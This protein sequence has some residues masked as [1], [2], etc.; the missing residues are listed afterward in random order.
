MSISSAVVDACDFTVDVWRVWLGMQPLLPQLLHFK[1]DKPP[2]VREAVEIEIETRRTRLVLLRA[3][4][5]GE[6]LH[7]GPVPGEGKVTIVPLTPE[8]IEFQITME[9]AHPAGRLQRHESVLE[10][11]PNGPAIESFDA[12]STVTLGG[13]IG[14]GWVAPRSE[15]TLLAVIQNGGV[16]ESIGPPIGQLVVPAPLPG[17]VLLR[18]TAKASW[19]T[20]TTTKIVIVAPPRLGLTLLEPAVQVGLP[21]QTLRFE[22]KASG[23]DSLWLIGPASDPPVRFPDNDGGRLL[24]KLG[25]RPEEF[26][27]VAR[28]YGGAERHVV[29]RALPNPLALLD[30]E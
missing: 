16:S 5:G 7:E 9:P 26:T 17:K 24:V 28:G 13:D 2:K 18:L 6:I 1:F 11:L 29:L 22:F 19:G 25:D 4:Q 14:I 30:L 20:S 12:P 10:P 27:V 15:Q 8:P 21:G 3:R 23:A